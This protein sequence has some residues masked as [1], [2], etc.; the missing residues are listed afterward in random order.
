MR[1]NAASKVIRLLHNKGHFAINYPAG[2]HAAVGVPD[3][4]A[5]LNFGPPY[6]VP[7][8]FE[9]KRDARDRPSKIQQITFDRMRARGIPVYVVWTIQQVEEICAD[10]SR[11]MG[12]H[13]R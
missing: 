8:C 3:I 5:Y 4:L 7:V 11:S 2:P 6:A 1:N 13:G 12:T 10:L 9:I